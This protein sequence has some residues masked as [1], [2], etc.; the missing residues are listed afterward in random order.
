MQTFNLIY[1]KNQINDPKYQNKNNT[2]S[3]IVLKINPSRKNM[4]KC[5]NGSKKI[6]N[7]NLQCS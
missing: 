1:I 5:E 6:I 4:Q 2:N 7:I 3:F